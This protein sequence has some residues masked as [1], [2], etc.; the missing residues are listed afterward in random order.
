MSHAATIPGS[1][2]QVSD[3][4][5]TAPRRRLSEREVVGA[6]IEALLAVDEVASLLSPPE[7]NNYVLRM[8]P[9][10]RDALAQ[11]HAQAR[12]TSELNH[13]DEQLMALCGDLIRRPA[14]PA[15]RR[16][17]VGAIWAQWRRHYEDGD[18]LLGCDLA[19][20]LASAM[21]PWIDLRSTVAAEQPTILDDFCDVSPELLEVVRLN[22]YLPYRTVVPV[23]RALL[24]LLHQERALHAVERVEVAKRLTL[25]DAAVTPPFPTLIV[26]LGVTGVDRP[27]PTEMAGVLAVVRALLGSL[28][29]LLLRLRC[30]V[31]TRCRSVRTPR[32]HRASDCTSG[33]STRWG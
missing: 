14:I 20:R 33:T 16:D 2:G 1:P 13:A 18:N 3:P 32:C 12:S 6:Q 28:R 8:I 30:S 22:L 24:S 7:P 29:V 23:L 31:S 11:Y 19:I 4:H 27:G 10:T 15:D 5:S 9:R 26:Y 25:G 17:E 21:A